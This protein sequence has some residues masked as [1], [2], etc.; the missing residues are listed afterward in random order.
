MNIE[1]LNTFFDI[2]KSSNNNNNCILLEYYDNDVLEEFPIRIIAF[3]W[4]NNNH[5]FKIKKKKY[6]VCRILQSTPF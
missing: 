3:Y 2:L 5:L 4:D 1:E 6:K